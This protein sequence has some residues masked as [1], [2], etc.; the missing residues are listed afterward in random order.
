MSTTDTTSW[1]YN[2]N[3]SGSSPTASLAVSLN[4]GAAQAIVLKGVA[5]SPCPLNG[6]NAFGPSIQRG[7][8]ATLT[9][10]GLTR[11]QR[12]SATSSRAGLVASTLIDRWVTTGGPYTSL[13]FEVPGSGG[14]QNVTS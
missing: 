2:V 8:Q 4:G 13:P 1:S 11:R 7:C 9:P 10:T 6:S 14:R 12:S 5:Y 3:T